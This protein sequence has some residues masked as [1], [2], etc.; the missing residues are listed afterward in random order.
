MP[1]AQR[2]SGFAIIERTERYSIS[3]IYNL[4]APAHDKQD[5]IC[6]RV[7]VQGSEQ[8][9]GAQT[10]LASSSAR[11]SLAVGICT[12]EGTLFLVFIKAPCAPQSQLG[13]LF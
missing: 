3:F 4:H 11:R 1:E 2:S 13:L 10:Q 6:T 7:L 12:K 5:V 9:K 8:K